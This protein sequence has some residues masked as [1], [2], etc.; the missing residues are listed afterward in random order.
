MVIQMSILSYLLLSLLLTSIF[1]F[2]VPIFLIGV[3]WSGLGLM[4]F[5]PNM[6]AIGSSGVNLIEHFLSTFGSGSPLQG[7][8]A[9]GIACS[10]VG[11][12]F[13]GYVLSQNLHSHR[14]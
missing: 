7:C 9:I 10:F 6:E 4:S 12:L 8:L 5:F 1:S 2:V 14:S 13:E 11:V 3:G